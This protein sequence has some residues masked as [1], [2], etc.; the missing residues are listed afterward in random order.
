MWQRLTGEAHATASSD[1]DVLIPV[2]GREQAERALLFLASSSKFC[3]CR[4][5][6]ELAFPEGDI[7]WSE[8][9]SPAGELVIK[10]LDAIRLIPREGL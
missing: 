7:S 2:S 8:Y 6:G 1:L 10:S 3:P 9:A 5:D 4:I